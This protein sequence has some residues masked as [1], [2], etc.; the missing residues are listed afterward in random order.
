MMPPPYKKRYY[1]KKSPE[2]A[3]KFAIGEDSAYKTIQVIGKIPDRDI[4]G[5]DIG[6]AIVDIKRKDRELTIH[7]KQD[8]ED[9]YKGKEVKEKIT[10]IK[11]PQYSADETGRMVR[12]EIPEEPVKPRKPRPIPVE[13]LLPA[14]PEVILPKHL[15]AEAGKIKSIGDRYYLGHKLR[16]S[17][18]KVAL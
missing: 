18:L 14:E 17:E 16:P 2:G 4:L 8:V 6:I 5:I 3:Y 11:P 10:V 7:F 9:I 15:K 12:T 1:S 13:E